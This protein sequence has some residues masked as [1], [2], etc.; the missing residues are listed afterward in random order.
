MAFTPAQGP[1][2]ILAD[3]AIG[4]DID[5]I[6]VNDNAA[7]TSTFNVNSYNIAVPRLDVGGASNTADRIGN[8]TGT[9][10]ITIG[11]VVNAYAGTVSANLATVSTG[12]VINKDSVGTVIISG[13][14]SLGTSASTIR[15]GGLTLDFSTAPGSD[16]KIGT[17]ALT[18]GATLGSQSHAHHERSRQHR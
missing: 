13:N 10:T 3:N 8:V 9:G 18:L 5:L 16:N 14:N 4:S 6:M 2:N 15:E 11:T 17:G 12:T 7:G 1:A